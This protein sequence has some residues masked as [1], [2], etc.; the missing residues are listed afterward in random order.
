MSLAIVLV[1]V[2]GVEVFGLER[3]NFFREAS[4]G[5]HI[6][7]YWLAKALE[8]LIWIPLYALIFSSLIYALSPFYIQFYQFWLM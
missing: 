4:T 1:S 2:P 3:A 8:T 5:L 7:A 6:T